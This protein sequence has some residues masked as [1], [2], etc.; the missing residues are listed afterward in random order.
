MATKI[1]NLMSKIEV[2]KN[3]VFFPIMLSLKNIAA[4]SSNEK[5]EE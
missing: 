1:S 4:W 3:I 5:E 2:E